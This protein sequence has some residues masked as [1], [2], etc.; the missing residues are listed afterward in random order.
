M[1]KKPKIVSVFHIAGCTVR[2]NLS[3]LDGM[4]FPSRFSMDSYVDK[5]TIYNKC[6]VVHHGV[7]LPVYQEDIK[8][9]PD[10]ERKF[11]AG[12]KFP[13]IGMVGELRKNQAEL[14]DVAAELNNMG[15]DFNI[16]IIGK[17]TASEIEQLEIIIKNKGLSDRVELVGHIDRTQINDVFFDLDIAVTTFRYDVFSVANI[18]SLASGTPLVAYRSGGTMEALEN[19]GGVLVDGGPKEMAIELKKLISDEQLRKSMSIQARKVAEKYYSIDSMGTK[20]YEFYE[21][22]F[23]GNK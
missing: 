1:K 17:G 22:L 16:V 20:H 10:R 8:N 5:D 12:K 11:F 23:D 3:K 2:F 14:V 6:V 9:D 18:E 13:V 4:L 19:G 15:I 7:Q 21:K